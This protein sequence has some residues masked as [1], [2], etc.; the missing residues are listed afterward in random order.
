IYLLGCCFVGWVAG[1]RSALVCTALSVTCLY[2]AESLRGGPAATGWLFALN[3]LVRLLAYAAITW[4][5]AEAGR[6][7]RELEQTVKQRTKSLEGEIEEH[8]ATAR[9]HREALELFKQVA[10]NVGDVFWV[11]DPEKTRVEYV[12]PAFESLW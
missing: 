7:T 1:A 3:S 4:L 5:A 12:S 10:E 2:L 11:T 8:K 9:L 6:L